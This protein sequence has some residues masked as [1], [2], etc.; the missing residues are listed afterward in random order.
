MD[1]WE[2]YESGAAK[3]ITFLQGCNKDEMN[4]FVTVLGVEDWNAWIAERKTEKFGRLLTEEERAK[5]ESYC[6]EW[7]KEDWER[8]SCLL[9]Q[10][11]FAAPAV[12]SS[13]SLTKGGGK[14]YT[15]Y[16]RVESVMPILKSGHGEELPI[17]FCH[18]EMTDGRPYD[19]TFSRTM[20]RM[21]VQFAKTGNPSLS[22]D[23]SPDGKAKEWP[24]YDPENRQVM[25]LDE[26]NIHPARESEVKMVDWDRT[27]F[28]TKYY[29]L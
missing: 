5:I 17:V 27:Y 4:F 16:Y 2:A 11:W 8:G 26:D 1:L 6:N 14:V 21:W 12:R 28:L 13:E 7:S 23:I 19:A 25:V 20:R 22:A 24:L 9:T 18:P 3:D 10:S 29:M 15:Y